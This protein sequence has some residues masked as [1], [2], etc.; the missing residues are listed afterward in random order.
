MCLHARQSFYISQ[1]LSGC[2]PYQPARSWTSLDYL[3][4]CR[5]FGGTCLNYD[6]DADGG[7]C[8][9]NAAVLAF[10][11]NAFPDVWVNR[12]TFRWRPSTGVPTCDF[13]PGR[14]TVV[15]ACLPVAAE[16]HTQSVST[17]YV[18]SFITPSVTTPLSKF[19][20]IH[21]AH[22]CGTQGSMHDP[23]L[24]SACSYDGVKYINSTVTTLQIPHTVGWEISVHERPCTMPKGDP[25]LQCIPYSLIISRTFD[26]H[27]RKMRCNLQSRYFRFFVVKDSQTCICIRNIYEESHAGVS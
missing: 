24:C 12:A 3:V 17:C 22:V 14:L 4:I 5:H 6:T 18:S 26:I 8:S 25:C 9:N 23:C 7:R 11:N 27:I 2:T 13:T 19:C 21:I 16:D 10:E 1:P 15:F 20:L